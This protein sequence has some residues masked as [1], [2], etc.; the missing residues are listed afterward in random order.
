MEDHRKTEKQILQFEKEMK[1]REDKKQKDV[2]KS[3]LEQLNRIAYHGA[4]QEEEMERHED[5]DI[6]EL[7]ADNRVLIERASAL[8]V[9]AEKE[10]GIFDDDAA[11]E[12]NELTDSL[13]EGLY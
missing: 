1:E 3:E 5:V 10:Q 2:V 4:K 6:A 9:E 8:I 12:I 11:S 13:I 7:M